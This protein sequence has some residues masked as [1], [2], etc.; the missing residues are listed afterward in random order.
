MRRWIRAEVMVLLLL[1]GQAG[2]MAVVAL[3]GMMMMRLR[4]GW[5]RRRRLRL[6]VV[7][8]EGVVAEVVEGVDIIA[9]NEWD[10]QREGC[11]VE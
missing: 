2:N 1:L 9:L 8:E 3:S 5:R 10:G 11:L 6:R 4:R 7:G